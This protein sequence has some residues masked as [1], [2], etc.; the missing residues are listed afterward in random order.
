[1]LMPVWESGKTC[2]SSQIEMKIKFFSTI[3]SIRFGGLFITAVGIS[4][5][6]LMSKRSF[7]VDFFVILSE[8]SVGLSACVFKYRSF[9]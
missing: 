9:L 4:Y 2:E 8:R 3:T 6:F 1:M 5:K 7:R